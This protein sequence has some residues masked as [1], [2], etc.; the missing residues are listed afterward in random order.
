M[1]DNGSRDCR[2]GIE[3]TLA[4]EVYRRAIE[5]DIVEMWYYL[6]SQ[7]TQL[8]S[9][10]EASV[11]RS[12]NAEGNI[13]SLSLTTMMKQLTDVIA[14]GIDYKRLVFSALCNTA[15]LRQQFASLK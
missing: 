1:S 3:P 6:R 15:C 13:D 11:E 5:N 12:K 10:L 4:A 14:T 7:L 8:R 2:G 9:Q